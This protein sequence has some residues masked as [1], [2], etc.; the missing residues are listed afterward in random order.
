MTNKDRE[1][2]QLKEQLHRTQQALGSLQH[3]IRDVVSGLDGKGS[4]RAFESGHDADRWWAERMTKVVEESEAIEKAPAPP[5][6][7]PGVV[8][9]DRRLLQRVDELQ[10]RGSEL[11]IEN[12]AL[13]AELKER[14]TLMQEPFRMCDR[15]RADVMQFFGVAEQEIGGAP[16]L[17]R[18][19]VMRF[20]L[21]LLAEEVFELFFAF[22]ADATEWNTGVAFRTPY[23]VLLEARGWVVEVVRRARWNPRLRLPEVVKE[24]IDLD[25]VVE[26]LRVAF[27]VDAA[28]HW[29]AV[30]ESNLAKQG[31]PKGMNGKLLKPAGWVPPDIEGIL[32]AQG[33]R[34][35]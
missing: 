9:L 34:K 15:R 11:V 10:G 12:R 27:G 22:F 33:W 26:G 19:E 24:S 17:P 23:S 16:H 14:R 18:D 8:S 13:R 7:G 5:P 29:D 30:H 32:R 2:R 25:Y 6:P 3:A 35:P 31:G 21:E 20:R 1:L 4:E 28:P